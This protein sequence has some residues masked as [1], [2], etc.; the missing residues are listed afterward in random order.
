MTLTL[1]E[2]GCN[3][4]HNGHSEYCENGEYW[5]TEYDRVSA[6]LTLMTK[7]AED[8]RRSSSAAHQLLD[9]IEAQADR[10]EFLLALALE[11]ALMNKA[12]APMFGV[13]EGSAMRVIHPRVHA[14]QIKKE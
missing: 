4:C 10:A 8:Y 1:S 9:Y 12:R 11:C 13:A 14:S 7:L 6:E 3:A 2:C 5:H